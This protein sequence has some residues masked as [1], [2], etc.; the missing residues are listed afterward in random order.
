LTQVTPTAPPSPEE[1]DALLRLLD[2]ETPEVRERV[3]ERIG[4]CGGDISE[5]LS[6]RQ[7]E[8]GK[9]DKALLE[10]LLSPARRANLEREWQV[11]SR[12]GPALRED[13][14]LFEACL[15]SLSDFL[16]DGIHLRQS[17]SDALDLLAE[18]AGEHGIQSGLKLRNFLFQAGRL[19]GNH[20]D[21]RNLRNCDLAWSIAHGRSNPPGLCAIFALL[22]HRLGID[23]EIVDFPDHMLCRVFEDGYPLI[24]DCYDRGQLHLQDSLLE[25]PDLRR[26]DRKILK[27]SV[28]LDVLLVRLLQTLEEDLELE[29][30]VED[31]A[32][33]HQLI[34]TL[35]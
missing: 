31:A 26:G 9:A 23:V 33:V 4:C 34:K 25:S 20:D 11:P 10:R 29:A 17:L 32:L 30:R 22:G 21:E 28:G 16:H 14:D 7:G 3:A 15:R 18:E 12:G 5:W 6:T 8:L 1:L 35:G 13:W 27:Q 24:I 2:D 19:A